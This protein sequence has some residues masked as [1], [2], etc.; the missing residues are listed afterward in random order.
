MKREEVDDKPGRTLLPTRWAG[1]IDTV[2]GN[3]LST[4]IKSTKDNCS[5]V[6]CGLIQSSKLSSTVYPFILRRV[7]LL[8]LSSSNCMME[9][10]TKIW[11]KLA[12]I[13]KPEVLEQIY[14]ECVLQELSDK[15]DFRR[16]NYGKN[17]SKS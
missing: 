8:G 2:G 13:W 4:A 1:V 17:S 11:N 16:E 14:S 7:N 15:I 10:R 9:L 12:S 5:V 3:T 6:A